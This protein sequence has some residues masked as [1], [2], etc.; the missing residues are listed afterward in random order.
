MTKFGN[1]YV[2]VIGHRGTDDPAQEECLIEFN[3]GNQEW[4]FASELT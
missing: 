4:V 2:E 3:D 1:E